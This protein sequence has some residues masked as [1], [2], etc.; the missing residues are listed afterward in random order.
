MPPSRKLVNCRS[1]PL[2]ISLLKMY[3]CDWICEKGSEVLMI[4][5]LSYFYN[6]LWHQNKSWYSTC[7]TVTPSVY[8][9]MFNFDCVY[10]CE[11]RALEAMCVS[12][13]GQG[14]LFI[15]CIRRWYSPNVSL[16]SSFSC[17][18]ANVPRQG[19]GVYW[20]LWWRAMLLSLCGNRATRPTKQIKIKVLC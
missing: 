1:M 13:T 5:K 3:I 14:P 17:T 16:L 18:G 7:A 15:F 20:Q 9:P 12:N 19:T 2:K 4:F 6:H 10:S 11:I 8:T